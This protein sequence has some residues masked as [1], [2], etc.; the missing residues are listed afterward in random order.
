M[1]KIMD[2]GQINGEDLGSSILG[3]GGGGL[4]YKA[5]MVTDNSEPNAILPP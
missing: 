4:T 2:I 3:R 1:Q 5:I